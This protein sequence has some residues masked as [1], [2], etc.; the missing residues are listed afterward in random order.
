MARPPSPAP[1]HPGLRAR[2]LRPEHGAREGPREKAACRGGAVHRAPPADVPP[3]APRPVPPDCSLGAR[4]GWARGRR[5]RPLLE[6][7][8]CAAVVTCFLTDGLTDFAFPFAAVKFP[9]V[10]RSRM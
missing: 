10:R 2:P 8:V 6:G 5:A 9:G 7:V 4:S 3:P 1:A